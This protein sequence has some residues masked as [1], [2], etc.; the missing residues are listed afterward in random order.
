MRGGLSG[1]EITTSFLVLAIGGQNM[2]KMKNLVTAALTLPV[3]VLTGV[4]AA[5][6]AT[7]S[8]AMDALEQHQPGEYVGLHI[9]GQH[10]AGGFRIVHW[11]HFDQHTTSGGTPAWLPHGR[12]N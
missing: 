4:A 11:W 9:T 5:G 6:A 1:P 12:S 7:A 3:A 2:C 10:S 8:S